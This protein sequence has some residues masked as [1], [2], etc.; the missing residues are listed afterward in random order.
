MKCFAMLARWRERI[1]RQVTT[2]RELDKF[3]AVLLPDSELLFWGTVFVCVLSQV[4][5]D[6]TSIAKRTFI[7]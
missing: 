4:C 1:G 3:N 5:F 2:P 6:I 7:R